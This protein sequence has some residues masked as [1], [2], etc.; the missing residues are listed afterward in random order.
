M[1]SISADYVR[2]K[3]PGLSDREA[4]AELAREHGCV[5]VLRYSRTP[6]GEPDNFATCANDEKVAAYLASPYCNDVEIL[7]DA[8]ASVIKMTPDTILLGECA[9]CGKQ[10]SEESLT[11]MGGNDF[12]FCPRCGLL[13]CDRC[14]PSLPLTGGDSGYGQ[15]TKCLVEVKR[16]LPGSYGS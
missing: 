13:F 14:Y 2:E 5:A 15:C 4:A 9:S 1:S 6:G 7:Y 12:Y 8:R 10:T 16:A 11:L 3:Y